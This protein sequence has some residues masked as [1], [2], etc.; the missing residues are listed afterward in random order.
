VLVR[1]RGWCALAANLER[2]L[3]AVKARDARLLDAYLDG[4]V[5]AESYQA[6]AD[7]LAEERRGLEL[8]LAEVTEGDDFASSLVEDRVRFAQSARLAYMNGD[9]STRREV[10]SALLWNLTLKDGNRAS[11]QYKR[12]FAVL[13]KDPSG[14][15]LN[16]WWA[17]WDLNPRSLPC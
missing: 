10:V 5:P 15:F 9:A 1:I 17:I 12:P 7:M 11:Y 3:T 14:A 13:Q 6:K 16:A 2:A 8:Q 4:M